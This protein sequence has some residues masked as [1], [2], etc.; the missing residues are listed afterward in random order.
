[1]GIFDKLR[2]KRD[3]GRRVFILGLDGTPYGLMQDLFSRG[4]LKNLSEIAGRGSLLQMA[5]T[6]PDVS[7]VAWTTFMTGVN[8]G[9][10][11]I[12]GFM[13]LKPGTYNTFFPNTTNIRA[14]SI[15]QRLGEEGKRSVIVNMPSTYPAREINGALIAG[16]VA[17]DLEKATYPKSLVPWLKGIGYMLDV[18]ASKAREQKEEFFKD[19]HTSLEKREKTFHKLMKE[20]ALDLFGAI[21]TGTDRLHHFFWDAYEEEDSPFHEAFI[22]Y[23]RAIDAMAGRLYDALNGE[24]SFLALSDHG[25]CRLRRDLYINRWLEEN[26]YLCFPG[27]K[28]DS[29]ADADPAKTR[30]F[31]M[32]PGRIYINVKRKYPGGS[33]APGKACEALVEELAQALSGLT[34]PGADGSPEKIIRGVYR[35]E[36]LFSGPFLTSAPD[37]VLLAEP[38]TNLK[39]ATNKTQVIDTGGHFTGMHSQDDAFFL[40]DRPADE[41]ED[42]HILDVPRTALTLLGASAADSIE[43]KPLLKPS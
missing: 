11:G 27:E 21:V 4:V 37:L 14:P 31:C 7:S 36:E 8:P 34:A 40:S 17:I 30:A 1:M 33:V 10:H 16:F 26:G 6:I 5:T 39:G 12:F 38:G 15:W 25:F 28:R 19:L 22:N 18:D 24:A 29:I 20:E 13:D 35:R 32:D 42:V 2:K 23:Y 43:G 9:K 41:T 3:T